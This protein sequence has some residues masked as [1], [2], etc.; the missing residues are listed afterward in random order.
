MHILHLRFVNIKIYVTDE[1]IIGDIVL[2][3][4][5]HI[6]SMMLITPSGGNHKMVYLTRLHPCGYN[7]MHA[8]KTM[9]R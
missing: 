9:Q 5:R 4:F 3:Y 2:L 1:D 8:A 7:R 6:S